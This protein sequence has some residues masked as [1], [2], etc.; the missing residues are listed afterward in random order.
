MKIDD[1]L[2]AVINQEGKI[3]GFKI[4]EDLIQPL[5]LQE[6]S[7]IKP[8]KKVIQTC[9]YLNRIISKGHDHEF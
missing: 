4:R 5:F 2:K 9:L 3:Q 7:K 8:F 1:L 6:D